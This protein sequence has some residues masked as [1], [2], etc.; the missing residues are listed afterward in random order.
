MGRKLIVCHAERPPRNYRLTP[1]MV[2][3]L[4]QRR[5]PKFVTPDEADAMAAELALAA[6]VA[7]ARFPDVAGGKGPAEAPAVEVGGEGGRDAG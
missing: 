3:R 4:A 1:D 5:L 2:V 7:R 6:R